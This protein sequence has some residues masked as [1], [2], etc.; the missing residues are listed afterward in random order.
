MTYRFDRLRSPW[1]WAIFAGAVGSVYAIGHFVGLEAA[2]AFTFGAILGGEFQKAL[3]ALRDRADEGVSEDLAL[4]ANE[5]AE[6][7]ENGEE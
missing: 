1:C 5:L 6:T 3:P 4:S 7:S 2:A